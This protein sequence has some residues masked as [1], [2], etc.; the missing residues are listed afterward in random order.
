M[1]MFDETIRG[2]TDSHRAF[3]Y[4]DYQIEMQSALGHC[5]TALKQKRHFAILLM[6]CSRINNYDQIQV[7]LPG[8]I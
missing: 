2:E 5:I 8:E 4:I 1:M 7:K 6:R 3:I